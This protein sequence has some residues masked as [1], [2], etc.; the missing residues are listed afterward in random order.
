MNRYA[1]IINMDRA[2][3]ARPRMARRDRAKLFAPFAALRG[4]EEA[5][6]RMEIFL[7]PRPEVSEDRAQ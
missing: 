3:P 7:T 2:A 5:V 4:L 6:G 1:D